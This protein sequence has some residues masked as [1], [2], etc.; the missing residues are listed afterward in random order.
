ME[1]ANRSF[2]TTFLGILTGVAAVITT[3]VGLSAIFGPASEGPSHSEWARRANHLCSETWGLIRRL[4]PIND[5]TSAAFYATL[6]AAAE[7][8][9][10]LGERLRSLPASEDDEQPIDRLAGSMEAMARE[11]ITG[12]NASREE[13]EARLSEVR[14]SIYALGEEVEEATAELGVSACSQVEIPGA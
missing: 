1:Q 7:G 4:P 3:I 10:R 9:R 11:I 13:D 2:W 5:G 8:M 14:E 12:V 6:P